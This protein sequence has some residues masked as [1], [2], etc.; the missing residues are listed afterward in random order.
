MKLK[1][2]VRS[3]TL[4]KKPFGTLKMFFFWKSP[5]D[6]KWYMPHANVDGVGAARN[7][8][9]GSCAIYGIIEFAAELWKKY[10]IEI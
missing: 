4:E 3:H 8:G 10:Y 5:I 2:D 7:C 1:Q 6:F 9:I